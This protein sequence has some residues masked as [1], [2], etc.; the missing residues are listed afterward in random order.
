MAVML[1]GLAA[2]TSRFFWYE[3]EFAAVLSDDALLI[4]CRDE[5]FRKWGAAR[6]QRWREELEALVRE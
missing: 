3:R 4:G 5:F 6:C 2:L 1:A